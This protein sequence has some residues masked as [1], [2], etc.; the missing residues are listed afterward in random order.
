MDD[1]RAE[2]IGSA[3]AHHRAGRHAE[4]E[5]VCRAMLAADADDAAALYLCGLVRHERG[6]AEDAIGLMGRLVALQPDNAL[7]QA[8]LARMLALAGR[9]GEAVAVYG[10]AAMLAPEDAA[11]AAG[12]ANAEREAGDA[13]AAIATCR[14]A[15]ARNP[16][17]AVLLAALGWA[18]LA[19]EQNEAVIAALKGAAGGE[20]SFLRGAAHKALGDFEAAVEEFREAVAAAPGHAAAHLDLG[21]SLAALG[22]LEAAK[23][24]LARAVALAPG[25]AEAQASL[26]AVL[27]L[28]GEEEAAEQALRRALAIDPAMVA[29]HRNLA[30]IC[31]ATG[32]DEEARGHRDS[33]YRRQCVFIESARRPQMSVLLLTTAGGGN[34]PV[35]FLLPRDR[36][37]KVSWVIEHAAGD[38]ENMLPPFDLVFNGMGDADA[39]EAAAAAVERFLAQCRRPVLNVP[40][41]VARTRR[42]LLPALL[43]DIPGIAVPAVL[44]VAADARAGDVMRSGIGLPLV[45]RRVGSHGG[46]GVRLLGSVEGLEKT[47]GNA[48]LYLTQ[49]WPFRSPDGF[50]RKYRMIFVDRRPL[51]YH[52][53]IG[54]QWLVHYATAGMETLQRWYGRWTGCWRT[55]GWW[56]SANRRRSTR[57]A[58]H[59]G[60]RRKARHPA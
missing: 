8:A 42:D 25:R 58:D 43:G 17:N 41:R 57:P 2:K 40:E 59:C 47:L 52:L 5:A 27:L 38:G 19:A 18:L 39:A 48:P 49:F 28:A 46:Q 60:A 37:T 1:D 26:G 12:L 16:G 14:A 32:R 9:H 10:A 24:A 55:T 4:A 53:A 30:A 23:A 11:L 33:A 13:G 21:N 35:Q 50:F 36:C 6:D 3:L 15:L 54:E 29:A 34:V 45:A 44:R 7:G 20:I 22:R 31:E 51:P 56:N